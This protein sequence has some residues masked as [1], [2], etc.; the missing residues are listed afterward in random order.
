MCCITGVHTVANVG[1][2]SARLKTAVVGAYIILPLTLINPGKIQ[3]IITHSALVSAG[4]TNWKGM[5]NVLNTVKRQKFVAAKFRGL[6]AEIN[7]VAGNFRGRAI[8]NIFHTLL[9]SV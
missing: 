9:N 5:R 8:G 7:F 2:E 1:M 4:V 6:G 3:N